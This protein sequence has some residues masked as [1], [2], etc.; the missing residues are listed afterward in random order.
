M[1]TAVWIVSLMAA[2]ASAP[3][4]P[5]AATR[6]VATRPATV[7]ATRPARIT[8]ADA[9]ANYDQAMI[10]ASIEYANAQVAAK[11]EYANDLNAAVSSALRAQDLDKANQAKAIQARMEQDIRELRDRAPGRSIPVGTW[12]IAYANGAHR[13]YAIQ[14]SGAVDCV[15]GECPGN[16]ST[17][18]KVVGDDLMVD[19][20]DGTVERLHL[21]NKTLFIE[22]FNPAALLAS[23]KPSTGG[24][25][26]RQ[27]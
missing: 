11:R 3:A 9:T 13:T 7:A 2:I 15:G 10:R 12:T 19:W 22:H 8:M 14:A 18:I 20:H 5:T 25:G 26:E 1:S 6:P 27:R 23:E 21:V 4:R 16:R 24:F 17:R